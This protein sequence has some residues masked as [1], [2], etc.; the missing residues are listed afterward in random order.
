MMYLSQLDCCSV[1]G[2]DPK[3]LR[4]WMRQAQLQFAPHPTDARLKCLS[5]A[6]VQQLAA[7][8]ARPL[9]WPTSAGLPQAWPPVEHQATL[10]D[11]ATLT[12][13]LAHLQRSLITL[14]EQVTAL[15]LEVARDRQRL[16]VL[17]ALVQPRL[18]SA[19]LPTL[20]HPVLVEEPATGSPPLGQRLLPA[21]VRARS[22]VTPLIEYG[23]QGGYVLVCPHEGTLPFVPDSPEWFD[24]LATLISFRFV[25][26]QG[27]RERS[28]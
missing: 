9:P 4:H 25:G 13:H 19:A 24:W 26:P 7:Q 2:I 22:R 14:Q 12:Q 16:G 5:Q 10:T 15:M 17:E 6:Q 3:T 23:A 11:L 1:L 20:V 27:R 8:H 21:E 18:S 28:P